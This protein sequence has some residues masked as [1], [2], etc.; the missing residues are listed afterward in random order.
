MTC[1][2]NGER[3]FA[4]GHLVA[5]A[6]LDPKRWEGDDA[7]GEVDL[8][9]LQRANLLSTLASQYQKPDDVPKVTDWKAT[10]DLRNLLV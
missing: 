10:P 9:P 2:Q 1:R 6:I 3:W 5:A 8:G 7:I 4:Q